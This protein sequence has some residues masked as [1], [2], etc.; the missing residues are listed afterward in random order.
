MLTELLTGI[1]LEYNVVLLGVDYDTHFI[2]VY[3]LSVREGKDTVCAFITHT[4]YEPLRV[5]LGKK[6]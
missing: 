6:R 4:Q 2:E 1:N 5:V 3:S